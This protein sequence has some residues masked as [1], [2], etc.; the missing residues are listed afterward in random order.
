M[1]HKSKSF[2]TARSAE[3]ES[4]ALMLQTD[5]RYMSPAVWGVFFSGWKI[6]KKKH[7]AKTETNTDLV[8]CRSLSSESSSKHWAPEKRARSAARWLRLSFKATRRKG[9]KDDVQ[10]IT[11]CSSAVFFPCLGSRYQVAPWACYCWT[12]DIMLEF[13]EPTNQWPLA[14]NEYINYL[15]PW[16]GQINEVP[17]LKGLLQSSIYNESK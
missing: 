13:K 10:Q 8:Q 1:T 3:L 7:K 6:Q 4:S 9:K 15:R 17:A 16:L 5:D 12:G 2:P 11:K 14:V